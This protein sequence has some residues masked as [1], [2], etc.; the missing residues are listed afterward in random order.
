MEE[1]FTLKYC[2]VTYAQR[3]S[4]P[5]KHLSEDV[6]YHDFFLLTNKHSPIFIV[7]QRIL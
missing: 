3:I 2:Y 6:R 1:M 4:K 7:A 5:T